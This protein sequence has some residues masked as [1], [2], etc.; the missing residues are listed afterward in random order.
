MFRPEILAPAGNLFKLK[1]AVRYGA[2]AVYLAGR[3]F[4]LR[5]AEDNFTHAEIEA[6]TAFAHAHGCAV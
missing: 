6:G 3:R 5:S 2:D 4:G 1:T